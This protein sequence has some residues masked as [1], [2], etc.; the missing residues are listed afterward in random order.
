MLG[1]SKDY[2]SEAILNEWKRQAEDDGQLEEYIYHLGM[3]YPPVP[4]GVWKMK[5]TALDRIQA[6]DDYKEGRD[7]PVGMAARHDQ[8]I[9]DL[10]Y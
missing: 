9:K 7:L 5:K 1:N 2:I 4:Y 6:R 8:L 10:G 3:V